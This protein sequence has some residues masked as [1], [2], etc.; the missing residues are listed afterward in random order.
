MERKVENNRKKR[1]IKQKKLDDN[2]KKI[3]YFGIII[4]SDTSTCDIGVV[5][6]D[7]IREMLKLANSDKVEKKGKKQENVPDNIKTI[8][9]HVSHTS[10]DL[11]LCYNIGN[12]WNSDKLNV[13]GSTISLKCVRGDCVILSPNKLSGFDVG[14]IYFGANGYLAT[15]I[16]RV[17]FRKILPKDAE[18]ISTIIQPLLLRGNENKNNNEK[19]STDYLFKGTPP[20]INN[21][22]ME[23]YID[24]IAPDD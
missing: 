24:V 2:L 21:N 23:K 22:N 6:L 13:Y 19:L 15:N 9:C 7:S 16:R 8:K 1:E 12:P 17:A 18:F 20:S 4:R 14:M 3:D 11:L 10:S 5:K